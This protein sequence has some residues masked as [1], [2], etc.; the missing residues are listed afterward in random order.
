[1]KL[2]IYTVCV[3]G[4]ILNLIDALQGDQSQFIIVANSLIVCLVWV[5]F[6]GGEIK[7]DK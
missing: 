5:M 6:I 7:N 4:S 1:V 3:I 2:V